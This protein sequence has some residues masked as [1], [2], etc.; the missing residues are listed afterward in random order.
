VHLVENQVVA[1]HTFP[2]CVRPFERAGVDDLRGA[3]DAFGL[4]SRSRVREWSLT[5]ELVTIE[6]ARS[7]V[8]RLAAECTVEGSLQFQ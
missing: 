8:E 5:I 1:G 3:V 6:I 2:D 7:K 4:V